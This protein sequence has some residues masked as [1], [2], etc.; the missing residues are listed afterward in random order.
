MPTEKTHDGGQAPVS[1]QALWTSPVLTGRPG[2]ALGTHR[3]VL[4][5]SKA[6]SSAPG[7]ASAARPEAAP[8]SPSG[9]AASGEDRRTTSDPSPPRP[10]RSARAP[11]P[12]PPPPS[13]PAA[14]AAAPAPARGG[15]GRAGEVREQKRRG[16]EL[17]R[18]RACRDFK[19]L[20]RCREGWWEGFGLSFPT[21]NGAP[22]QGCA[23]RTS[24]GVVRASPPL[25]GESMEVRGE[26][27]GVAV[28][29]DVAPQYLACAERAEEQEVT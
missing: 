15:A 11:R 26:V 3:R 29:R 27:G 20:E 18:R 22:G 9:P 6:P 28:A 4:G 17:K 19:Y 14:R 1:V 21:V 7:S 16:A 25:R 12:G 2:D 10:P 24:G 8:L 5:P 13:Y 23:R